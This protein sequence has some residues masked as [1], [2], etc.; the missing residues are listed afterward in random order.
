MRRVFPILFITCL[1]LLTISPNNLYAG[2]DNNQVI[3]HD[4]ARRI[5][6][7][8]ENNGY[9]S[10]D[11]N[12]CQITWTVSEL[13]KT[14]PYSQFQPHEISFYYED[15]QILTLVNRQDGKAE[16][17]EGLGLNC[18]EFN[19]HV[20]LFFDT[21]DYET[22]L[23][24]DLTDLSYVVYSSDKGS[25]WSKLKSLH[26]FSAKAKFI[27]PRA[28]FR[29]YV[30]IFGNANDH[31]LTI[32]NLR[33]ETTYLLDAELSILKTVSVYN[34]L[35]DFDYPSDFAWHNDSLYL[36]RGSCEKVK[37]RIQC[38]SRAYMETS[39]DFGRT[40]KKEALPFIKKSYF[41]TL[42]NSL[43][44][45]YSTSCPNSW[46]GL[47]PA[48]NQ[49][50]TC[51]YVKVK[52]LESDGQWGK[53]KILIET[54]SRLLGTYK[55]EKPILVWQ[56]LRFHKKRSCGFIPLIGCVDSAPFRGPIVIYAG[57]LDITNWHIDESIIKYK[58]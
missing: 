2:L 9:S 47:I 37:G 4:I 16:S 36:V 20:Y 38:P 28:R 1:F 42:S 23:K 30:K 11:F 8:K 19:D 13:E 24:F 7:L 51:G 12:A 52:K 55:D 35:S 49:S 43:Y 3:N 5:K 29:K 27:L 48:I 57:E 6:D 39:K 17:I 40:W 34:R 14:D 54:A 25:S 18:L 44:Q 22:R 56:D 58:N 15:Q 46:F 10:E 45:F 32:F 41:L 53:S 31:V 33:D 50:F 21:L 26:P